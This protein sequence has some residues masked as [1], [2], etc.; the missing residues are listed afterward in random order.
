[1]HQH[2]LALHPGDDEVATLPVWRDGRQRHVRQTLQ[3]GTS[4]FGLQAKMLKCLQY[5]SNGKWRAIRCKFMAQL[6]RRNRYIVIPRQ[7]DQAGQAAITC[8]VFTDFRLIGHLS[9][10]C[11]I[12]T[13]ADTSVW[14]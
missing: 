1:L 12:R 2:A 6:F 9:T 11:A 3:V 14:Q 5:L 4:V 8:W 10:P 7:H 13:W